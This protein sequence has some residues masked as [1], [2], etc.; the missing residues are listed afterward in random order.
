MGAA[1][2]LVFLPYAVTV[3]LSSILL[4]QIQPMIAKAMLP[5]FGGAASVWTASMLFFQVALLLGYVYAHWLATR[6]TLRR[7]LAV[8]T[9]VIAATLLALPPVPDSRWG[10]YAL[11]GVLLALLAS[12]GAPYFALSTTSPLAQAWMA[13]TGTGAPYRLFAVSNLAA[14]AGLVAYP[15]VVEPLAGVRA[16]LR[17]WSF[18]Y[19]AFAAAVFWLAALAWRRGESASVRE[20]APRERIG[21]ARWIHWVAL[22]A[23][24]SALLFA[25]T[26]Y[27]CQ[28]VAPVPFLW[29]L[30]LALY[31]ATFVLCFG[32]EG[33]YRPAWFRW[34]LLPA[35]SVFVW[36]EQTARPRLAYLI[37][38]SAVALLFA[39][40]FCHGEL[41]RLKPAPNRLTSF[42]FALALG[43]ALGGA[44]VMLIA[45]SLYAGYLELPGGLLA[46]GL[47]AIGLARGGESN[48]WLAAGVM[49]AIVAVQC[50]LAVMIRHD[51]SVIARTRNFYGA[52]RVVERNVD[53]VPVR[54]LIHNGTA[55]GMQILAPSGF[56][57]PTLYFGLESGA[58]R[59]LMRPHP[60]ARR[61]GV[62]GL[63][64]GTLAAY[65]SPRDYFRFYEINPAVRDVALRHFEFL[66][67]CP[68]RYDVALG[69]A[70]LSL[71]REP[72]QNFDLLLIDAFSGDSIPVHLLTVEAFRD[73]FRHVKPGG[74]LAVHISNY[75]LDLAPV[76]RSSGESAGKGVRIIHSRA[77]PRVGAVPA[78]WAVV[79]DNR[80][81]LESAAW[82]GDLP[83]RSV[84]PW[85][86]D[87][88]NL[89]QLLKW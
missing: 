42:Y 49:A 38:A 57:V 31:L 33:W 56:R 12:V 75:Y 6:F 10:A 21:V 9:V 13:R 30:P 45:P 52:L 85:T 18:G 27:L 82:Q 16:Q 65:G 34:A 47:L 66:P 80:E 58:G 28:D 78:R 77:N 83:P 74:A 32:W 88:S 4:F 15:F 64:A 55:H 53:G 14:L 79:T 72:A 36:M 62:V 5:W 63:G 86:D 41:V 2:A 67:R 44:Y 71:Q 26:N 89:F 39:C 23:C 73:Y 40:L 48:K 87:Y 61:I 19:A 29:I 11:G 22:P 43:G 8:H 54:S 68:A 70:R 84:R 1:G 37:A 76:V 60:G 20:E 25:V 3:F 59:L 81:I 69:D 7:Q 17:G 35:F 46:C 24:A 51:R 50:M